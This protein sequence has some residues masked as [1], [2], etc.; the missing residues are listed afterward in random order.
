[1]IDKIS[2][3]SRR[4]VIQMMA[5]I[6]ANKNLAVERKTEGR[7]IKMSKRTINNILLTLMNLIIRLGLII[8]STSNKL[9]KP[10]IL[11]NLVAEKESQISLSIT[12]RKISK[13]HIMGIYVLNINSNRI[14]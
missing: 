13:Y 2:F 12:S 14:L 6:E 9:K 11:M 5:I 7:T 1:M 8:N 10:N 3:K 4:I